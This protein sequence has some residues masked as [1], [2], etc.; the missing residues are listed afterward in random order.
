MI[1]IR[2]C[3]VNIG[4]RLLQEAEALRLCCLL[5]LHLQHLVPTEPYAPD[6]I[7]VSVCLD[8]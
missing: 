5:A 2:E 7:E 4:L 1:R 3:H 8:V 6:G